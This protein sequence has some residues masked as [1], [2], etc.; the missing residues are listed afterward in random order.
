MLGAQNESQY[1]RP[2]K[3]ESISGKDIQPNGTFCCRSPCS[4]K[5]PSF[6]KEESSKNIQSNMYGSTEKAMRHYKEIDFFV[7]KR[8][9]CK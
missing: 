3:T 6:D 2:Q 1:E 5:P 9:K 7:R 4:S 8:K